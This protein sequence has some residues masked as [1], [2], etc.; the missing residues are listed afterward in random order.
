MRLN[1]FI[2]SSTGLSRRAADR[3]ILEGRVTL[4]N[5][6]AQLGQ[7]VSESDIVTLDNRPITPAVKTVTILLNKPVG[8]VC[9]R[10]GQ[11]SKTVYNLLPA[12]LH[13]LKPV[14][15]LDKNSSGL[16]LMTNDGQLAYEL[17]HPKFQKTKVYK[18]ALNKPL[19]S[20][21]QT[22]ISKGIL[23]Q[24]GLS[25]LG[26]E[27]IN[28]SDRINWKITM[29]EGR[30]RQIRRTFEAL[31][32]SLPKLHRTVFGSYKL[33]DLPVGRYKEPTIS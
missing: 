31:G 33:G 24:D 2:A 29:H 26:L 8:Y 28:T 9:S 23:L 20:E 5:L 4:N 16:M 11:G 1:Q 13:Q 10:D 22:L 12:E 30:N 7:V 6:V 21:D 14:G 27:S 25:K 17:T 32:Y 18:I 15:R 3:A 19:M